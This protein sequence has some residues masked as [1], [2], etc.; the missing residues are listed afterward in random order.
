MTAVVQENMGEVD[1]AQN[2]GRKIWKGH[3][4]EVAQAQVERLT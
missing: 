4:I 2:V 1:D 3:T